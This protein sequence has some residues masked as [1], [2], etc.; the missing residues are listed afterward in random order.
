MAKRG[1]ES[2]KTKDNDSEEEQDEVVVCPFI[3]RAY[4]L[5]LMMSL[6]RQE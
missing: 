1:A 3:N 6:A 4:G 5:E 2:Q